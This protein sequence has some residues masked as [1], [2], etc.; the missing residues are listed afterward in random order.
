MKIRDLV[1]YLEQ[2]APPD[3]QEAYD[4]AGLIVGNPDTALQG[5]LICLDST[6]AVIEE[7]VAKGCNLVIAHHPIV[8]KGLKRLTGRNYVERTVIKAIREEV[9]I[10]AIHTNLDNVYREGVNTEIARRLELTDTRLLAPKCELKKLSSFIPA[11]HRNQVEAAL[12]KAGADQVAFT[13]QTSYSTVAVQGNNG[14]EAE[15]LKLEAL[16]TSAHRPAIL[17][18]LYD[19]QPDREV[20]YDIAAVENHSPSVGAGMIGRLKAPMSEQA[21]LYLLK[22]RM[23]TPCIRHTR[24]LGK[25]VRRVAVCGGAGSFLRGRA[26]AQGADAFVTADFKYHE[27]FDADGHLLI[28]DIGHYESEQFT[29][30]LLHGIISEKFS[31]FAAYCTEVNTNPVQYLY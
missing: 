13:H 11:L 6:E 9:A 17:R 21:F 22:D 8:F 27:F 7:A 5:V 16:F 15:Y 26:I 30:E 25:P 12:I 20:H 3:Y 29:I 19:S 14:F 1:R 31:N 4:N 10:Y 2:V 18:A 28:A 24:R 23:Q